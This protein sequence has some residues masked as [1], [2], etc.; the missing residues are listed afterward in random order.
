MIASGDWL[1]PTRAT[2]I[3]AYATAA[4]CCAIAWRRTE[5]RPREFPFAMVL[6][7]VESLL[8]LDLIFNWRWMLHQ[9][10]MDLALSAHEYDVRRIP[11][12]IV[13]T[14]LLVLLV[15]GL[16]AVRRLPGGRPGASLAVSGALLSLI[17]WCVEVVSLHQVDH[18]LYQSLGPVMAVSLLWIL[19]CLMTSI[20]ILLDSYR[21]R[22]AVTI[23]KGRSR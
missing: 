17:L 1:T 20:G 3:A 16:L 5:R 2:G 8:L 23:S 15:V 18:I 11:Q 14:I 6:T 21:D 12:R 9:V 4:A 22:R 19:A 13:V 10:F 7:L